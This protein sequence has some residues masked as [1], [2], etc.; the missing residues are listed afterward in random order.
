MVDWDDTAGLLDAASHVSAAWAFS[1]R[2]LCR[3]R[4]RGAFH[5]PLVEI[6][7]RNATRHPHQVARLRSDPDSVKLEIKDAVLNEDKLILSGMN[8]NRGVLPR[9]RIRLESKCSIASRDAPRVVIESTEKSKA[10]GGES[11]APSQR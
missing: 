10:S 8:V 6:A 11:M 4:F 5:A 9:Q 2:R 7:V 1:H 3:G